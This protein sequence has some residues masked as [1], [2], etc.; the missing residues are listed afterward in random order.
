M[1]L[2]SLKM[3]N[4][5]ELV[6]CTSILA[7]MDTLKMKLKLLLMIDDRGGEMVR[8]ERWKT[9]SRK[10]NAHCN[11]SPRK[12]VEVQKATRDLRLICTAILAPADPLKEQ[13]KQTQSD[14][15]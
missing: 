14:I 8:M 7:R 15:P 11:V 2:L 12:G 5:H 3:I 6:L 10:D 9:K 1:Q 4:S 13:T